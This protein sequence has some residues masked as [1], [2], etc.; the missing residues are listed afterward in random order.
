MDIDQLHQVHA[1]MITTGLIHHPPAASKLVTSFAGSLHSK[2]RNAH[3][4]A[5]KVEGLDTY[6]WNRIIKGYL[7]ESD[8]KNAIL[9]YTCVKKMGLK[10]DSYTLLFAVKACGLVP[11]ICEGEQV[12]G[13]LYKLGFVSELI[14]QTA[15]LTMYGLFDKVRCVQ[16][17]FDETP[18]RD[19]VMWNSLLAAYVQQDYHSQALAIS[20]EMVKDNM[21]LNEMTVV[22]IL[23]AC[24]ALRDLRMG[25]MIHGFVIR[26]SLDMDV[27]VQNALIGMYLKCESLSKARVIF[28]TMG[29]RNVVSWTSMINGFSDNNYLSE[30]LDLFREM[31]SRNIKPD[32]ITLLDEIIWRIFLRGCQSQGDLGL[33]SRVMGNFPE[34]GRR[35][36]EDYILLSNLYATV[37]EWDCVNE[38]R[39]KMKV[40]GVIK[41]SPGYSSIQP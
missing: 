28:Q 7:E 19:I 14:I 8:P 5:K 17:V 39:K 24:S 33:A 20:H 9:V 29:A 6:T 18:H 15:L 10:V 2:T 31:E 12:H 26:N 40:A 36:C 16:Q 21:K 32:E 27:F 37:A 4:I 13:Q 41:W 22:S 38:I 1:N 11:E 23:S 34:H 3:L 25:T 30:A 35:G